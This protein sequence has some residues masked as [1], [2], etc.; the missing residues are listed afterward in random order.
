MKKIFLLVVLSSLLC[1]AYSQTLLEDN[2][3]AEVLNWTSIDADGYGWYLQLNG[4]GSA[5]DGQQC[6]IS[7]SWY[8]AAGELSPDNWLI[9]QPLVIDVPGYI[10]SW[11]VGARDVTDHEEHYSVYIL[12]DTSASAR[13]TAAVQYS[14]TLNTSIWQSRMHDLSAFVG[15]TV[16]V[17]FRHHDCTNQYALE[18]DAVS[19]F[20]SFDNPE[21]SLLSCDVDYDAVSGLHIAGSVKNLSSQALTSYSVSYFIDNYGDS[22][23]P[24]R[25]ITGIS[26]VSGQTTDF[27]LHRA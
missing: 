6:V 5:Y 2:F 9:S 3:E 13:S 1:A 17:A 18:I 15:Q 4:A 21:I 16:Y 7:N 20:R 23:W 10:L 24:S 22:V 12:T 8:A 26:V 19:V 11:H 25:E 27:F 14:E